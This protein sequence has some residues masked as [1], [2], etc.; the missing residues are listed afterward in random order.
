MTVPT[1]ENRGRTIQ[2]PEARE[3]FVRS[4][5]QGGHYTSE[6]EVINEA[7]RLLE[8]RDQQTNTERQRIASLLE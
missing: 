4:L 1:L 8:Q 7:L 3:Q 2:L 5:V 6:A